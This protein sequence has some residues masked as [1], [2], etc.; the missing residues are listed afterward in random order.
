MQQH[1][2]AQLE[3][4]PTQELVRLYNTIAGKQVTRFSSREAGIKSLLKA[5]AER[6]KSAKTVRTV[7]DGKDDTSG[8]T[9]KAGRPQAMFSVK[10]ARQGKSEV[11]SSSLRGQI[12]AHL[13]TQEQST[14]SI[15][16]L[17]AKFGD[18]ARGAVQKLL[19]VDWLQKLETAA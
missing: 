14:A 19:S 9:S 12:I 3:A 17:E 18:K 13:K 11:R 6:A 8:K 15:A 5:L 10:L 16:D 4:M 7:R 2:R 1:T